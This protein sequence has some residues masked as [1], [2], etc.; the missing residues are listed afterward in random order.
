MDMF[1]VVWDSQCAKLKEIPLLINTISRKISD[2]SHHIRSQLLERLNK[3]YFATQLRETTDISSE[4][5]LL[6]YVFF[7]V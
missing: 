2:I 3:T 1:E 7:V 6:V 5:Q 4:L